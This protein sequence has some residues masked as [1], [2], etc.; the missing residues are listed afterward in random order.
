[1]R[2]TCNYVIK[3]CTRKKRRKNPWN[4][5]NNLIS[6]GNKSVRDNYTCLRVGGALHQQRDGGSKE[7]ARDEIPRV[8][9]V[10]DQR[11]G[12]HLPVVRQVRRADQ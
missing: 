2:K 12:A 6:C 3:P 4:P 1:M 10:R 9:D 11:D 7:E 5:S 8:G